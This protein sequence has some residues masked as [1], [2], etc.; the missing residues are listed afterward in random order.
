[1]GSLP[2]QISQSRC[3]IAGY[4]SFFRIYYRRMEMIS[5]SKIIWEVF[6]LKNEQKKVKRIR[7][8]P[9]KTEQSPLGTASVVNQ[10]KKRKEENRPAT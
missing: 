9:L 10:E 5:T 4:F 3:E 2:Q 6:L 1:M 8:R 7:E